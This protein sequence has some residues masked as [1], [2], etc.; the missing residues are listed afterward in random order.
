MEVGN[1]THHANGLDDWALEVIVSETIL[2]QEV[3]TNNLG[4][5]QGNLLILRQRVL[6]DKLHNLLKVI[7]LLQDLLELLL[8]E[9]VLRVE[10]REVWLQNADVLGEGDVPVDRREV[11]PLGKLLVQTPEDLHD[12]E[13]GRCDRVGEVSTRRRDSADD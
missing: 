1:D 5:L 11:L 6:T 8:Q 9:W 3:F 4:N 13:G 7:L 12:G 10:L 2:L